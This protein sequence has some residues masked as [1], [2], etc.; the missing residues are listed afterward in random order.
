[1]I[2]FRSGSF[3][4]D[5]TNYGLT[6]NE[7]SNMFIDNMI[8]S[9]SF[10]FSIGF[11]DELVKELD[12]PNLPNA[13]GYKTSLKGLL[14]I[15]DRYYDATFRIGEQDGR[16]FECTIYFGEET[17][18]VYDTKMKS[19]PWPIHIVTTSQALANAYLNEEWP[20]VQH[21]FPSFYRADLK[22]KTDY[23]LFE[24]FVNNYGGS[25]F[26]Q[27]QET[28]TPPNQVYE[29]KNVLSPCAYMLEMLIFGFKSEGKK[30][31]GS[32]LE[33]ERLKKL[34]YLPENYI[35]KFQ[36]SLFSNFE[37]SLPDRELTENGIRVGVYERSFTPDN[38]GT[39]AIKFNI[40]LDPVLASYYHF[41]IFQKDSTTSEETTLFEQS[42]RGN[43]VTINKDINV[44][45]TS[46]NQFD[47]IWIDL[48][49]PYTTN[50][51]AQFNGFEYRFTEGRLNE[52]I[53]TYSLAEYMPDMKFGE[54]VN[55]I[56]NWLNLEISINEDFV[57]IEFVDT[58]LD[59]LPTVDHSKLEVKYP[60]RKKNSD[61]VFRLIYEDKS[62]VL[63]DAT[64]QIYSDIEKEN[65]DIIQIDM[66][67]QMALVEQNYD[68]VTA[69][70][71]EDAGKL[72]FALYDGIQNSKNNCVDNIN[73][74]YGRVEDIY[75]LFWKNWLANR[76]NN[77]TFRDSFTAHQSDQIDIRAKIYKYNQTLLP[78]SI[79]KKRTMDEHWEVEMEAETI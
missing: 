65:E 38:I 4:I 66:E 70:F 56:K 43:R 20:D 69:V 32:V 39:Y 22:E 33:D 19:L 31:T 78:K 72:I 10:P 37:F 1:M 36:G 77:F 2:L 59:N 64:G 46:S 35:E 23:E 25:D 49:I 76:T 27:N 71:D 28:G 34:V 54:Y 18:P 11:I 51:I 7:E 62:E 47:P 3:E 61:R 44:N 6:L 50:S 55:A 75:E 13:D 53:G 63:V 8:K 24:H 40:N 26:V 57:N 12:L 79:S 14:I 60:K 16:D 17:L 15:D 67:V 73:N 52:L 21:N 48:R 29:N 5:L 45:I 68:Q 41:R 58:V 42:S 74:F 30:V 9:Y